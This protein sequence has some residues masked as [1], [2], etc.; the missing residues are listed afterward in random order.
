MIEIEFTCNE[1][2]IET[3]QYLDIVEICNECE[4]IEEDSFVHHLKDNLSNS[5]VMMHDNINDFFTDITFDSDVSVKFFESDYTKLCILN[6]KQ[7]SRVR[8]ILG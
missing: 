4:T 2:P 8:K 6:K 3:Q 5:C 1:N 7:S